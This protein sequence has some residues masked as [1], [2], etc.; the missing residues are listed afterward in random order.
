[1]QHYC[2]AVAPLCP[3]HSSAGRVISASLVGPNYADLF[4]SGGASDQALLMIYE[5]AL[6]V[7]VLHDMFARFHNNI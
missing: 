5:L 6:V 1:M 7:K 4:R 3:R 2:I